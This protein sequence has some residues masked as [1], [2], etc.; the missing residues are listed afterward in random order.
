MLNDNLIID[1]LKRQVTK[2]EN[3]QDLTREYDDWYIETL[4]SLKTIFDSKH[5]IVA[6]FSNSSEVKFSFMV[7][8]L[9]AFY[10]RY[11]STSIKFLNGVVS[12]IEDFGM[13]AIKGGGEL[14]AK[15]PHGINITN[16]LSNSQSQNQSMSFE[17]FVDILKT[18]LDDKQMQELKNVLSDFKSTGNHNKAAKFFK[19]LGDNVL[20]NIV[21]SIMLNPSIVN[22]LTSQI[23]L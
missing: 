11:K 15:K 16:N 8:N 5:H 6:D 13:T 4:S 10:E 9:V 12:Q 23:H 18:E 2:L 1:K 17:I 22:Q 7:D 3:I 14:V 21:A 20:A 19:T